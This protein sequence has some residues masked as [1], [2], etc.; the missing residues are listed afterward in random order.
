MA[1]FDGISK[2]TKNINLNGRDSRFYHYHVTTHKPIKI[3]IQTPSKSTDFLLA[4]KLI[5]KNEFIMRNQT[6]YPRFAS[7]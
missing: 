6:I 3:F 5:D 1:L 7:R 4:T 2:K